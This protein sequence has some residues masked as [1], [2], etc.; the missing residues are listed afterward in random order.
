MLTSVIVMLQLGG[1]A[2]LASGVFIQFSHRS[3]YSG[4]KMD[5][6]SRRQFGVGTWIA[7][8]GSACILVTQVV[9]LFR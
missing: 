9:R 6:R 4:V 2:L 1:L 7:A 5:S 8:A 3:P